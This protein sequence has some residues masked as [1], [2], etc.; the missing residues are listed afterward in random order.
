MPRPARRASRL[1]LKGG[2]VAGN[3]TWQRYTLIRAADP[4]E[5]WQLGQFGGSGGALHR[6][7]ADLGGLDT[8]DSLESAVMVLRFG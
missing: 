3:V 2:T 7:S 1:G 6:K 5:R 8:A 4:S